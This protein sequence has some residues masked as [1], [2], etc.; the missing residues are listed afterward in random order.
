MSSKKAVLKRIGAEKFDLDSKIDSLGAT[1]DHNP[2]SI[3]IAQKNLMAAQLHAMS[4]Y[5]EILGIRYAGLLDEMGVAVET[6]H[7]GGRA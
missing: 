5:S 4:A 1:L 3:S 6:K 7:V 2:D